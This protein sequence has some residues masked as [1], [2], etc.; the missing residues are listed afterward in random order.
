MKRHLNLAILAAAFFM[1]GSVPQAS[2]QEQVTETLTCRSTQTTRSSCPI[3]GEILSAG[4]IRQLG[5]GTP[6]FLNY[7]WGFEENGLWTARGC[8]AEFAVTVERASQRQVDPEVLRKRLQAARSELRQTRRELTR[9]QE[10]RRVLEAELAEAQAA[11][12]GVQSGDTADKKKRSKR[13][14]IRAVAA[15][16][17]RAERDSR[18][19]GAK[20]AN[21]I[22]IVSARPTQGSWLVVGRLAA[23][24]NDERAVNYFRCWSEGGKVVSFENSI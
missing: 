9:E 13:R 1:P 17:N 6:C 21:V 5:E 16:S 23:T 24:I 14:A 2:A 20:K 11:L 18:K 3:S 15:C 7:T 8:S 19:S 10:D 22:E 4:M 12:R